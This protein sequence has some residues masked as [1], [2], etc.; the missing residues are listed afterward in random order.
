MSAHGIFR[1]PVPAN[2]PVRGYEPGSPEREELRARLTAMEAER[3]DVPCIIG[4]E[5][6]R[7]GDTAA[8]VMPHRKE[9]VLADVHQAG[10]AEVERAIAAA[11]DAWRDWSRTP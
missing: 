1:P 8:A 6:V 9:H 7:T 4:G 10:Q 2:E 5:D 11:A 3:L